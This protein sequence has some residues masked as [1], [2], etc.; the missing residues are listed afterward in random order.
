M[1]DVFC[2]ESENSMSLT[3]T[4]RP[5]GRWPFHGLICQGAANIVDDVESW[6]VVFRGNLEV[7]HLLVTRE[8]H[9]SVPY[10]FLVFTTATV[11]NLGRL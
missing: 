10:R 1:N 6:T 5:A 4:Q 8:M 9:T 2:L 3:V 7:R 11:S